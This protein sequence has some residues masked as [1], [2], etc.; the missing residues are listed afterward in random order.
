MADVRPDVIYLNGVFEHQPITYHEGAY[1][2]PDRS[3]VRI[4]ALDCTG[5]V[6]LVDGVALPNEVWAI[7]A[8]DKALDLDAACLRHTLNFRNAE[9]G[10]FLESRTGTLC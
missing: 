5:L 8:E 6:F 4:P 3:E 1:G 2:Y 7:E 9:T 10:Q